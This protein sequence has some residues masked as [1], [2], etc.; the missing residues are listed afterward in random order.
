MKRWMRISLAILTV[1]M[2]LAGCAF[3]R[4]VLLGSWKEATSG[5]ILQFNADGKVIQ[6]SPDAPGMT[7]E[8]GYQFLNDT[9]ILI[10]GAQ[11][12]YTYTV[13]GDSLTLSAEGQDLAL[14]RVR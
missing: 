12:V 8:I 4:N 3:N 6:S 7:V 10:T 14:T 13:E 9:T 2:L 11:S 5:V 1:A